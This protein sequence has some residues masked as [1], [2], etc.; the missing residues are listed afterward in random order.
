M[1]KFSHTEY[2]FLFIGIFTCALFGLVTCGFQSARAEET[3]VI[4]SYTDGET[5]VHLTNTQCPIEE[6]VYIPDTIKSYFKIAVITK[7]DMSITEFICYI[8][9][10][11]GPVFLTSDGLIKLSSKFTKV[12]RA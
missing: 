6:L 3:T 1:I 12:A 10:K 8:N 5:L 9:D 7:F 11:S 2:K 4:E